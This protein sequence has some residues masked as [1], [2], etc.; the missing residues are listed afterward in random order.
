[1]LPNSQ[2]AK[3]THGGT[4]ASQPLATKSEQYQKCQK[5]QPFRLVDK[6]IRW[7]DLG[8]VKKDKELDEMKLC[9]FFAKPQKQMHPFYFSSNT[10]SLISPNGFY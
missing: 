2:P 10:K 8:L 6:K 3:P 1:M 7:T 9:S 4:A 5:S